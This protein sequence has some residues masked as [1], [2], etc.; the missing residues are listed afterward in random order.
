MNIGC[1]WLVQMTENFPEI[2][3]VPLKAGIF[4]DKFSGV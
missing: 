1:A 4:C 2:E 3:M